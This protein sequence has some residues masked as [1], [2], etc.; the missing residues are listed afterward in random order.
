MSA[1]KNKRLRSRH[2]FFQAINEDFAC[3]S[4]QISVPAREI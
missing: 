3:E 1:E 2:L 4:R